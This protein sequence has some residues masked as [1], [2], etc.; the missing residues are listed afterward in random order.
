[1]NNKFFR[2]WWKVGNVFLINILWIICCIPVITVGAS[3]AAMYRAVF[4]LRAGKEGCV[5]NFFRGFKTCFL[6]ATKVWLTLVLAVGAIYLLAWFVG[7]LQMT[8]VA[9]ITAGVVFAVLMILW[10]FMTCVFPLVAYFDTSLKK[11]L[12]N[13]A[14][15]AI[16][17]GKK[18]IGSAVI[19]AIPLGVLMFVPAIFMWTSGFWLL[20]F[21]GAMAYL[22]AK[23]FTPILESYNNKRKE[24]EQEVQS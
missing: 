4:D 24:K 18:S 13:A 9:T 1:M 22:I 10:L 21:P 17:H 3:C 15:I 14:F 5:K 6:L 7:M 11:T 23:R 2:F 19:C 12:R 8:G 16:K 20:I